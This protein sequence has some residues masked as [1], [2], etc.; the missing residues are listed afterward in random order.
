[1]YWNDFEPAAQ[2]PWP[3]LDLTIE[4]SDLR[5][6]GPGLRVEAASGHIRIT[7]NG[8]PVMWGR[9]HRH[10]RGLWRLLS[11]RSTS[12]GAVRPFRASDLTSVR[13]APGSAAWWRQWA[14]VF[15]RELAV[16]SS[17]PLF[18]ARWAITPA[19]ASDIRS[20]P[21]PGKPPVDWTRLGCIDDVGACLNTP[22][23]SWESWWI[24]GSGAF[25]RAREK[26]PD[27]KSRVRA[28]RKRARD[29]SL[30]PILVHYISG[31]DMFMLLD[32]HDRLLCAE[33]EGA[34]PA[35]L[36]LWQVREQPREPDKARGEIILREIEQRRNYR[37]SSTKPLETAAENRVLIEAFDD[38]PRLWPITRAYP[39]AGGVVRWREEVARSS[40]LPESHPLFTGRAPDE[41]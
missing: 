4:P 33:L 40:G 11:G 7:C 2:N 25:L 6:P 29:G 36:V 17:T 20:A 8:E 5:L 31:L 23:M 34:P 41:P 30:P 12:L 16:S 10:Y 22:A 9:I 28:L 38:R 13:A 39:L 35:F 21:V 14:R 37:R 18:P 26:S 24:N 32:G 27:D 15:A 1:M 3:G 19:R